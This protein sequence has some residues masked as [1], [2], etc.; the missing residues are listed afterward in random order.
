[1]HALFCISIY[2][3]TDAGEVEGTAEAKGFIG[4]ASRFVTQYWPYSIGV[5]AALLGFI[6]L[7]AYLLAYELCCADDGDIT[8][9]ELEEVDAAAAAVHR[10]QAAVGGKPK[11]TR[12]KKDD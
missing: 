1:M 12:A 2:P 4:T 7:I 5:I 10:T 8:E 6:A 3:C 9:K 11:G